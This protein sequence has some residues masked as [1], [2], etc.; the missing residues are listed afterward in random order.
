[1]FLARP[2]FGPR[3]V[4]VIALSSLALATH[5]AH[6]QAVRPS[7]RLHTA[8]PAG[9][10]VGTSVELTIA[11]QDIDAADGLWF[12]DPS[13]T[14]T[15]VAGKPKTFK[16]TISASAKPGEVDVRALTKDGI[17]NPR[18]FSIGTMPET[19]E[20]EPNNEPA[21]ARQL[22]INSV[23]NGEIT[24]TDVDW[25]TFTGK[26]GQR[27]FIDLAAQRIES[28]L[29][30][31]L[32]LY[33]SRGVELAESRDADGIDSLI[34]ITL[35]SDDTYKIKL[36][37]MT[38]SGSPEHFYRLTIHNHPVID[39]IFPAVAELGRERTFT[40]LGRNL[41]SN[42][43]STAGL[44]TLTQSLKPQFASAEFL[45]MPV[46][47]SALLFNGDAIRHGTSNPFVVTET[48]DPVVEEREPNDLDHP[49]LVT[50]PVAIAGDFR[51]ER[52]IDVYRFTTK[53]GEKWKVEAIA[54]GIGSIADPTFT[55]Q[56][57]PN[58]GEPTDIAS[59]DD[60]A[61]TSLSPRINLSSTDAEFNWTAPDD[62]TYQVMLN[63]VAGGSRSGPKLYYRLSI[64]RPKPSFRLFLTTTTP[65]ALDSIVLRRGGR[66]S[67]IV[68]AA[69]IDG[70]NDP[71]WISSS[72]LPKGVKVE[73]VIIPTNG[74][75]ASIVFE[76]EP[77]API[78]AG[79]V[80]LS[81]ASLPASKPGEPAL[82]PNPSTPPMPPFSE[83][84]SVSPSWPAVK[85]PNSQRTPSA[86]VRATQ[87]FAVAVRDG[88]PFL[89]SAKPNRKAMLRGGTFALDLS[90]SRAPGSDDAIAI[91]AADL[92]QSF[93][94]PKATIAKGANSVHVD[95]PIPATAA[96]GIYSVV[97]RGTCTFKPDPK[98]PA[99][100]IDEPANP[101]F[102]EIHKPHATLELA[103]TPPILKAGETKKLVIKLSQTTG[104]SYPLSLRFDAPSAS[105]LTS[106]I[107]APP[108]KS[109]ELTI[110][111]SAAK[112]AP[113]GPVAV[114]VVAL[115]QVSGESLE[116]PLSFTIAIAKP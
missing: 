96:P 86:V 49:Q 102:I 31:T 103:G 56:K 95:W 105:K 108:V 72:Q 77:N 5:R 80:R 30:A 26:R 32:H 81:G 2:L 25:F 21:N 6:A 78:G 114:K 33:N 73:P 97:L 113:P 12:S 62:G 76:T 3:V 115:A 46:Q 67:A 64:R 45:P 106:K 24:Q 42:A 50:P 34:D 65:N 58:T 37:D 61:N 84:I 28:K 17:S 27:V 18:I 9:G 43:K 94:A 22:A 82:L 4:A 15:P 36:H 91:G 35:P 90:A 92:P 99:F 23:A 54:Q 93:A 71:I 41:G 13:I 69:R 75:T 39:A 63:D 112:D 10:Q 44:E 87:G 89:L 110:E 19:P 40:I 51:V 57:V 53:K 48:D 98:G 38:Y 14:A 68:L 85:L 109:G 11:G 104:N 100:K 7:P 116:V 8:L 1:M 52:D 111:V 59:A 16:V 70:H 74:S 83:S 107:P 55:I 101:I 20:T 66:S 47:D 88:S 79:I 29:D 60:T